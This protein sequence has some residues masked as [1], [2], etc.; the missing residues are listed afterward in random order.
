[1]VEFCTYGPSTELDRELESL[2]RCG[3]SRRSPVKAA[4]ASPGAKAVVHQDA[5]PSGDGA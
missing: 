4:K 2:G 3:S 5:A 1:M